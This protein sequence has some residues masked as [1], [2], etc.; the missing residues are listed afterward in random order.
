MAENGE[1]TEEPTS[2]RLS[3][4]RDEGRFAQSQEVKTA[5]M[6]TAMLVFVWSIAP[7]VMNRLKINLSGYLSHF[8]TIH[9]VNESDLMSILRELLI[10]IGW[11]IAVP[12]C[13]LF[14]VGFSSAIAQT[15]WLVIFTRLIPD[16]SRLNPIAKFVKMFTLPSTVDSLR[17]FGKLSI[18]IIML[19]IILKPQISQIELLSSMEMGALLSYLHHLLIR[20]IFAV[21][22]VEIGIAVADWFFQR[23]NF[24]KTMRMTKQEVKEEN[25]QTEG[26]PM[27][28]ARIRSMR[29]QRAKQR[30]MAAVP[31]ADVII[32]NPTHYA[33]ALKYD[34]DMHAPVL[35][36]KG[37]DFM[38][39]KIRQIAEEHDIPIIENPPLARALYASVDIDREISEEHYVAVA[40]VITYV[41]KLKGK[42][43]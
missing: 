24:M 5:A 21:T 33:C 9:I 15:G 18:I 20:L 42:N 8:G 35:I 3:T 41:F 4:A 30:I 29:L 43:F 23:F 32:T 16:I 34:R 28:K 31:K 26:D 6:L 37:L 25:K 22:A 39:L 40:E 12:F 17:S 7:P 14:A 36:A 2:K 10:N 27:I 13:F 19:Y 11:I 1:K 38:A